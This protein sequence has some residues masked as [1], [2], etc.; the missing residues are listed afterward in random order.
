MYVFE[1]VLMDFKGLIYISLILKVVRE[2][3]MQHVT[4]DRSLKLP[5]KEGRLLL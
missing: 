2:V 5:R 3:R 1:F 4:V